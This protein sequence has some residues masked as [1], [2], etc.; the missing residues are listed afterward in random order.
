MERI[1]SGFHNFSPFA[2]TR[3]CDPMPA[4]AFP[5]SQKEPQ[6]VERNQRGIK[7]DLAWARAAALLCRRVRAGAKPSW[8]MAEARL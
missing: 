4:E 5:L 1:V 7:G 3:K 2:A 6:W 8:R